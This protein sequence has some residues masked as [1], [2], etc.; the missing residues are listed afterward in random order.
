M[1]TNKVVVTKSKLDDLARHIN[2]KA[3]KKEAMTID[4]MAATV[5]SIETGGIDTSD[6]TATAADIVSGKTV[7]IATGKAEGTMPTYDGGLRVE[8]VTVN[9][10][11]IDG[12]TVDGAA[13]QRIFVKGAVE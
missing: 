9:G 10:T 12:V 3:G 7:Y 13:V 4:E 5:D 8:T 11:A 6:A 1:A 2:A